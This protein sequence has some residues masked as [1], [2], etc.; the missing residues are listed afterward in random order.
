MKMAAENIYEYACGTPDIPA[1]LAMINDT[2]KPY[3]AAQGNS[4]DEVEKMHRA[5]CK[6]THTQLALWARPCTEA[7][8]GLNEW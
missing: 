3:L 6:S 8:H 5:W 1:F 4:E 2:I 7:N